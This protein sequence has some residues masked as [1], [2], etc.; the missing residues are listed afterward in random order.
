MSE[1][2]T[3]GLDHERAHYLRHVLRLDRVTAWRC[4]TAATASGRRGSTDSAR[5]GAVWRSNPSGAPRRPNLTSGCCSRPIKRATDRFRRGE[6]GGAWGFRRLAGHHPPHRRRP[7]QHRPAARQRRRGRRAVRA[8]DRAGN[9]RAGPAG[10]GDGRLGPPAPPAAMRRSRS[11]AAD[12][13]GSGRASA[14]VPPQFSP[15][16][17]G[18]SPRMSLTGC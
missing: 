7:S 1:G 11:R 9:P 4:S 6:S 14:R 13:G 12:R 16:P 2:A 17:K 5:A 18:A 8:A 10:S 3:V 15:A